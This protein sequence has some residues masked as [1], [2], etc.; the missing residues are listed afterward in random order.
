MK[1]ALVIG[2]NNY[3]NN[4]LTGA[5]N[6]AKSIS[7]IL[8]VNGNDTTNFEVITLLDTNTRSELISEIA[9][10]FKVNADVGLLYF[11]GHGYVNEL[12]GYIVTPDYKKYDEG[13]AM[14]D[15][16]SFANLSPINNKVIIID[17]C[18]SGIFGVPTIGGNITPINK[19]ISILTSTRENEP[20]KEINGRGVF[21]NLLIEGLK[22][23]AADIR[24]HIS[25]GGIYAYIDQALGAHEQRPVFKTN[26][27]EFVELRSII[28]QVPLSILR[29][30]IEYFHAP[31]D[32]FQLDPSFED[33]NSS[34]IQ[35]EVIEPFANEE[36]VLIFKHLQKLESVGLIIPDGEDHMYYA[37]MRSKTCK[38]T[39]LG[40][41]ANFLGDKFV[42]EIPNYEKYADDIAINKETSES[43]L[44]YIYYSVIQSKSR[45][46]PIISASNIYRIKFEKIDRSGNFK[47]DDRINDNQQLTSNDYRQFNTIKAASIE[48]GHMT[49]REDV[50][51]DLNGDEENAQ[52]A[53]IRRVP[54]PAKV[55]VFTGPVLD[56]TDPEFKVKLYD[57]STFQIPILFWKVIYYL[58]DNGSL[59]KA[60]FLMGQINPL[61]KD[62][63][64]DEIGFR[65]FSLVEKKSS[66]KPFLEFK[67][68]EN[69][70]VP[71]KLI[72][73]LTKLK[74]HDAIDRHESIKP[75]ILKLE[76]VQIRSFKEDMS[77]QEASYEIIGLLV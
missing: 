45:R 74:F 21:T 41:I 43:T 62:N 18:H 13:I 15:I 73:E 22:G 77:S 76:E 69:Y 48:K 49:K 65:D 14:N 54:D 35:H 61:R 27:T 17:C 37:A 20:A 64:I 31:T 63:L 57:G 26:V 52:K 19:G 28:P 12:G 39:S 34:N 58:K 55:S 38:L 56:N 75:T 10:F 8:K 46:V 6:D 7:A 36:N 47:K 40:Y 68:D 71:V 42:V 4:P 16:L 3:P 53:A 32:N 67:D 72:E 33:T 24:G 70:Q 59:Y 23:G 25:P 66:L 11:A 9:N 1:K 5:I 50:Q 44:D 2:I 29:K 60:G 51:W 30:L